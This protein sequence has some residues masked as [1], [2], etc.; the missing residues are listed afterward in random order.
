[1]A[2]LNHSILNIFRLI[3]PLT[4]VI[5]FRQ[6]IDDIYIANFW[7]LTLIWIQ[8]YLTISKKI[9]FLLRRELMMDG[10]GNDLAKELEAVKMF[11]FRAQV[12][13]SLQEFWLL[14]YLDYC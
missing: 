6:Y 14:G 1:M 3:P 4:T 12:S 7:D 13:I 2:T 8:E 5:S 10:V 9:K 11:I